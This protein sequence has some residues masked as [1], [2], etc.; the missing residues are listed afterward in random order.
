MLTVYRGWE[1][2]SMSQANSTA[3]AVMTDARR[4]PGRSR[5][6][7]VRSNWLWEISC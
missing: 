6:D 5:T 4:P 7:E 1:I 3:D 2:A